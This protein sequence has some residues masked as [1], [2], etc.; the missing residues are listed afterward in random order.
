VTPSI[1]SFTPTSGKVG[2][3]LVITGTGLTQTTRVTFGGVTATKFTVNSDTQVT[4]TVPTGAVT[5][6]IA[7]STTGGTTAS[8]ATFTVTP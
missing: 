4:V 2:T 8:S 6:K 3:S 5:G 1:T 7:V